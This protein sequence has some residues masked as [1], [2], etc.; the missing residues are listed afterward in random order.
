[1]PFGLTS[2]PSSAVTDRDQGATTISSPDLMPPIGVVR[3]LPTDRLSLSFRAIAT[4]IAK[5]FRRFAKSSLVALPFLMGSGRV[6]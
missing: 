5:L 6:A 2:A 3:A 1:M 4:D